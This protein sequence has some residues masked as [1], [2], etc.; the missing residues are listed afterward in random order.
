M[1]LFTEVIA[2]VKL[3]EMSEVQQKCPVTY[4]VPL[5]EDV[6][7]TVTISEAPFLLSSGGD[8]GNRT[9][10]AALHLATYLFLDGKSFVEGKSVL[11]LGSGLGF[12][13]IFCGKHLGARHVLMTDGSEAVID[14]A[15]TNITLNRVD[16]LVG[17]AVL[18]WGSSGIEKTL[19]FTPVKIGNW[20]DVVLGADIVSDHQPLTAPIEIV[21]SP[22]PM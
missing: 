2:E 16:Y 12:L 17:T 5:I 11:E 3:D 10:A 18:E 14:L 7:R 8:S 15:R 1:D 19:D 22:S 21:T 4:T 9:W 13:S 20:F 6:P